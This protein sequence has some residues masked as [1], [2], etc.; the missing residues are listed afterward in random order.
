MHYVSQKKQMRT[1]LSSMFSSFLR[2]NWYINKATRKQY[3]SGHDLGLRCE[4][5]IRNPSGPFF[6]S[7]RTAAL[8]L[9]NEFQFKDVSRTGCMNQV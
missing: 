9:W 7:T 3:I 6:K 2:Y 4:M 8:S 5:T 1:T